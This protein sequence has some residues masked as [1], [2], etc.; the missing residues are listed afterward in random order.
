[1]FLLPLSGPHASEVRE[2]AD[3]KRDATPNFF[4]PQ[5]S[6]NPPDVATNNDAPVTPI[7]AMTSTA[8]GYLRGAARFS[9]SA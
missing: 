7:T 1:M 3:S 8:G 9:S 6:L 5:R 2:N 4:I